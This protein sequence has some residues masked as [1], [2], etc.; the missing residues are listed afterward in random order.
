M[1]TIYYQ[2]TKFNNED[3]VCVEVQENMATSK[4]ETDFGIFTMQNKSAGFMPKQ[5]TNE[6][7]KVVLKKLNANLRKGF[8]RYYTSI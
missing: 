3:R 6:E 2:S 4:I 5:F 1:A 8:G 7:C